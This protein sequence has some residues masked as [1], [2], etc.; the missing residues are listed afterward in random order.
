M[1]FFPLSP[2]LLPKGD[3]MGREGKDKERGW[4]E[5]GAFY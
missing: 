1:N 5:V 2:L 3:A 4:G